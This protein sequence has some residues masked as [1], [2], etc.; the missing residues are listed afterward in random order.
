VRANKR[1]PSERE[2][3]MAQLMTILLMSE[4]PENAESGRKNAANIE[5]ADKAVREQYAKL[6]ADPANADAKVQEQLAQLEKLSLESIHL[7]DFLS[8][9]TS[10]QNQRDSQLDLA[11]RLDQIPVMLDQEDRLNRDVSHYERRLAVLKQIADLEKAGGNPD[12][13]AAATE[14][15]AA[16][17][18]LAK[19]QSK[20]DSLTPLGHAPATQPAQ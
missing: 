9:P 1:A 14:T 17:D 3:K 2:R 16:L 13:L 6:K 8:R 18:Q 7:L 10:F 15:L 12:K 19:A 20:L 5:V 4:R 11:K